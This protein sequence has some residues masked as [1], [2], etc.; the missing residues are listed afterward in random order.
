MKTKKVK[1]ALEVIQEASA[2]KLASAI[3]RGDE[4]I[5]VESLDTALKAMAILQK[6][7]QDFTKLMDTTYNKI[8]EQYVQGELD[9][10]SKDNLEYT[11]EMPNQEAKAVYK[12]NETTKYTRS[13]VT[14]DNTE[15]Q[16]IFPELVEEKTT[17]YLR[18]KA[19]L[20]KINT[21][22]DA[23]QKGYINKDV[24]KSLSEKVIEIKK[25]KGVK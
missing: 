23:I 18:S 24:S 10:I 5:K 12:V 7:K 16:K 22:D 25:D 17:V 13:G 11:I 4:S 2:I 1:V 19:Q 3:V 8:K 14:A 20:E 21:L 15:L 6:A 9:T